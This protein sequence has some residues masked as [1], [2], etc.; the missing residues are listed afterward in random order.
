MSLVLDL[1]RFRGT[2]DRIERTFDAAAFAPEEDF[3]IVAPVE[4]RAEIRKDGRKFRLVGQVTTAIEVPCSRCL[5]P[6]TIPVASAFD[7]LFLPATA[8]THD[9]ERETG[10]ED[11]GVSFYEDAE[12]DLGDVIREQVYLAL[13]MKPLCRED[14]RGLCPVCGINRNVGTC[15][16][17]SEWVDPR[18]E[19]LKKLRGQ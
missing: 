2:V 3:R 17:R 13:P 14:C 1:G 6:F 18:L 8:Q 11:V 15:A 19:A 9:P 7:L 4:V 12:I 5:E 10:E 16:C